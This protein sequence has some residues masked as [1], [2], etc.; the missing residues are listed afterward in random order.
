MSEQEVWV[1]SS[2]PHLYDDEDTYPDGEYFRGVRAEQMWVE[3]APTDDHEVVRLAD[4][5]D[6]LLGSC[7]R[8]YW[9]TDTEWE[10]NTLWAC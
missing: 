9:E 1:G 5:K 8:I 7:I 4:L 2:G 6:W 3:N 10:S